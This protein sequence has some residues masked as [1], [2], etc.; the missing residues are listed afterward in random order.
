[1]F[2]VSVVSA[3]L[4]VTFPIKYWVVSMGRGLFMDRGVKRAFL[5]LFALRMMGS[6]EESIHPRFQSILGCTAANQEYPNIALFSPRSVRKNHSFDRL[7]P[8]W[9]SRSVKY[10]SSPLLFVV[11]S[12]LNILRGCWSVWIGSFNHLAYER[13]IKFSV[14]P[15]STRATASALLAIK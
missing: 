13:F 11:P 9:T 3:L 15:E 1:M 6:W 10:L 5:A 8:V 2:R 7:G 4:M 14:A 12:T